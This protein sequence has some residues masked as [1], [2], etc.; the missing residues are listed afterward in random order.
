LTGKPTFEVLATAAY[1]GERVAARR[2]AARMTITEADALH[3]VMTQAAG[4]LGLS[5]LLVEREQ[6]R[7]RDEERRTARTEE[8]LHQQAL[9]KARMQ[10]SSTAWHGWFDGSAHPNPGQ[11]GIGALLC[12]P[13][14][15]RIEIS[16]RAGHGNSGEAEYLA[17]TALLEAA[18]QQ[19]TGDLTIYGDSQV[20]V[21][22]VNLSE[23]SIA[24]GRGAKGLEAHRA[25]VIT[26]LEQLAP[27]GAVSL[28]WVPR[29]RNG[30]ADRLSQ[31]AIDRSP[32][33]QAE[34]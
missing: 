13:A 34:D 9:R 12:G 24:A 29:H 10:P 7:A 26:L 16:R 32:G 21:N 19:T 27:L 33:A 4:A 15:E 20:V 14:G 8:K 2:L 18:A 30:D 23:E 6:L 17:L 1:K 11:I 3:Q 5:H 25:R 31:Q 22:D 28:R